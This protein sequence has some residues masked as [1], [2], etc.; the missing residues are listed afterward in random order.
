MI[1]HHYVSL[2]EVKHG[3]KTLV[4]GSSWIQPYLT[5]SKLVLPITGPT[6]LAQ[7]LCEGGKPAEHTFSNHQLYIFCCF[8]PRVEDSVVTSCF[9]RHGYHSWMKCQC[10]SECEKYGNCCWEP[11]KRKKLW[12]N[13]DSNSYPNNGW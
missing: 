2:P 7:T 12:L 13:L 4:N 6:S 5:M 8:F 3:N 10:N 11:Q 9:E 1:F